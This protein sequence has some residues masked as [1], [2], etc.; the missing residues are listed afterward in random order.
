[1]RSNNDAEDDVKNLDFLFTNNELGFSDIEKR[2]N[3]IKSFITHLKLE[4]ID[5]AYYFVLCGY[6][7]YHKLGNKALGERYLRTALSCMQICLKINSKNFFGIS[8]YLNDICYSFSLLYVMVSYELSYALS[9]MGYDRLQESYEIMNL[10]LNNYVLK[11][12][13]N[14]KN[15]SLDNKL[16]TLSIDYYLGISWDEK[17]YQGL[18]LNQ[19]LCNQF[20]SICVLY[21]QKCYDLNSVFSYYLLAKIMDHAAYIITISKPQKYETA[22]ACLQIALGI[23]KIIYSFHSLKI[24]NNSD[25]LFFVEPYLNYFDCLINI[26]SLPDNQKK[27]LEKCLS[28]QEYYKAFKTKFH[29]FKLY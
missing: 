29:S 16:H 5:I 12:E 27:L 13:T 17:A 8:F 1:M 25:F 18:T 14:G 10:T 4:N 9:S 20:D 15:I 26:I 11:D 22:E 2:I 6:Y 3:L 28:M 21:S 24:M 23:R 19:I 7:T